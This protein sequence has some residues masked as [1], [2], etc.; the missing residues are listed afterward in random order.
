MLAVYKIKKNKVEIMKEMI[1]KDLL[2]IKKMTIYIQ[3]GIKYLHISENFNSVSIPVND[4]II[5]EL[6]KILAP[7]AA[8]PAP[9]PVAAPVT[10]TQPLSAKERFDALHKNDNK[11]YWD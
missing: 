9:P 11:S 8:A 7:Y 4:K 10:N 1:F 2:N 5:G 3:N 6:A